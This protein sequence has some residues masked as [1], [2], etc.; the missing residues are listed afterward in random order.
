MNDPPKLPPHLSDILL[1]QT[2]AQDPMMLPVPQHVVLNH[3]YVMQHTDPAILVTG[4]TQ[5]FKP[6]IHTKITHKFVTTVYYAPRNIAAAVAS[7][8][9]SPSPSIEPFMPFPLSAVSRQPS[10]APHA[11]SLAAEL[12]LQ[13]QQHA[14][15]IQQ[16]DNDAPME[17]PP[18]HAFR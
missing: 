6:N 10:P 11:P 5:R 12:H 7:G 15:L 18:A 8:T 14:Q 4:I 2:Q 17:L 3:L 13:Q 1:N 16:L 9:V